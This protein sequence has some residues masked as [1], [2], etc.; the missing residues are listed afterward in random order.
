M[1]N[2]EFFEFCKKAHAGQTRWQGEDYFTHHCVPVA[3]YAVANYKQL[4]YL[5]NW[6][7]VKNNLELLYNIGIAH[8]LIEDTKT[9]IEVLA[10]NRS[11]YLNVKA[12]TRQEDES[13]AEYIKQL[14]DSNYVLA[15]IIKLSDL[16]LNRLDLKPSARKDKYDLAE[17]VIVMSGY[18]E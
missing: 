2:Q 10:F 1:N 12:L 4:T 9:D 3:E 15:K 5:H 13:Y 8:D 11:L 17:L 18:F 16:T 7:F 6:E 14:A